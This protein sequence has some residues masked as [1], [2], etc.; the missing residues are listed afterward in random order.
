MDAGGG[1]A[2]VGALDDAGAVAEEARNNLTRPTIFSKVLSFPGT[3]VFYSDS[4][5]LF[6]FLM[7]FVSYGS[8]IS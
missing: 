2:K 7:L 3:Q 1:A 8:I 6:G 4:T 5:Y